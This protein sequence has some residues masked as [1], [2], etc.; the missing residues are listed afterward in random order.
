[1][2]KPP[3]RVGLQKDESLATGGSAADEDSMV[4]APLEAYQDSPNVAG[5]AYQQ[6]FGAPPGNSNDLS[7]VSWRE[8]G[9]MWFC[10]T[11]NLDGWSLTDLIFLPRLLSKD[12]I[13]LGDKT[14]PAHDLEIADGSSITIEDGGEVL[15]L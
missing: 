15:F 5:I 11:E 13:V 7:V 14:M 1:M 6:P 4:W 3:H 2:A 10:D 8:S 12:V 9:Q